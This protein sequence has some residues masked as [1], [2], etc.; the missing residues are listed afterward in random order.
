MRGGSGGSIYELWHYDRVYA[1]D[2][3]EKHRTFSERN[4]RLK[5]KCFFLDQKHEKMV[6]PPSAQDR[7]EASP[8]IGRRLFNREWK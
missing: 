8:C 1:G 4:A 7:E 2:F 5:E 6:R 3:K